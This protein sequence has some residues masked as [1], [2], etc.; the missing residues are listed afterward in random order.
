MRFFVKGGTPNQKH[1]HVHVLPQPSAQ[2][3]ASQ[4]PGRGPAQGPGTKARSLRVQP[5]RR[6]DTRP[7]QPPPA[8]AA[9][10]GLHH[11][12]PP[13]APV[14]IGRAT[15]ELQSLMRISYAVFCLKKKNE[16][17]YTSEPN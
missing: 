6:P 9:R 2:E 12:T 5:A 10:D 14:Q 8:Q 1:C 11:R 7:G 15:S 13:P 17:K 16:Y 3:A 4:N